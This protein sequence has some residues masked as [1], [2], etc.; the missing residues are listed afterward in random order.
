MVPLAHCKKKK[1]TFFSSKWE[2]SFA[3][4]AVR[5]SNAAIRHIYKRRQGDKKKCV[6]CVS[7]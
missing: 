7:G 3:Y 5:Q 1:D 4:I 6:P 2:E